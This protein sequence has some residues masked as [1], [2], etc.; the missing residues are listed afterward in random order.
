MF[1]T[2]PHMKEGF[3]NPIIITMASAFGLLVVGF[4]LLVTGVFDI[5]NRSYPN[6]GEAFKDRAFERGWLPAF[7]PDSATN[8]SL[9]HN[10]DVSVTNA[11]FHFRPEEFQAFAEAIRASDDGER[12]H[13]VAL[14][15]ENQLL[16]EG[17]QRHEYNR[18][19]YCCRF[20]IHPEQGR[21]EFAAGGLFKSN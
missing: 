18:G 8:I 6:R 9:E 13:Q 16:S 5:D 10:S 14:L 17:Y 4:L 20:L 1:A 12:T 2:E 3:L 21:C 19:S 15:R 11:N 7:I